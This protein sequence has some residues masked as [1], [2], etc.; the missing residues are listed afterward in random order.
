M[1]T[2]VSPNRPRKNRR[3]ASPAISTMI[4]TGVTVVLVL[5]ASLYAYQNLNRQQGA[6]EF[7]TVQKSILAFDDAL[8]DIAWSRQGA[9]SAHFTVNYGLLE[10]L[11]FTSPLMINVANYGV[12]YSTSTGYLQYSISTDYVNFADGYKSYILGDE[13]SAIPAGTEG[14]GQALIQ[15]Q[16]RWVNVLLNFRVRAVLEGPPTLVNSS[17]VSYVDILVIKII[18]PSRSQYHGDFDLAARNMYLTT[19]SRGPYLLN[20]TTCTILVNL[21]GTE[22]SVPISVA[23]S[24]QVVFN[25]ITSNIQITA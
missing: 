9:R 16:S 23:G 20:G 17:L 4:I 14:F 25:F 2:K 3:A 24:D 13:K 10:V 1:K 7:E 18:V 22:S 6:S 19:D 11:P 21:R 5:I 12:S 15:Q 8:R